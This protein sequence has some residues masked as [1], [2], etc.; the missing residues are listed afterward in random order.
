MRTMIYSLALIASLSASLTSCSDDKTM[1]EEKDWNTTTYFKST[2]EM[3]QATFYKQ[4]L[5]LL[6]TQCLSLTLKQRILKL[7]I[8][9]TFVLIRRVLIILSGL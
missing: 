2:D 9:R 8:Y 7:C 5:D 4:L 1:I 3:G 6:E